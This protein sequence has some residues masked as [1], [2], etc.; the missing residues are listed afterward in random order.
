LLIKPRCFLDE[1]CNLLLGYGEARRTEVV[2]KEVEAAFDPADEGLVRVQP[3]LLMLG[4]WRARPLACVRADYP[5]AAA[6]ARADRQEAAPAAA[7]GA[8]DGSMCAEQRIDYRAACD[9]KITWARY[10]A[11]WGPTL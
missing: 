7:L 11:K 5:P 10:F 4:R 1:V 9:G 8:G 6:A 3:I 2:A